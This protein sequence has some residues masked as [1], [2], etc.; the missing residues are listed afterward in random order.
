MT[1]YKNIVSSKRAEREKALKSAHQ[2]VAKSHAE[3]L[4]ATGK[5]HNNSIYE[6]FSFDILASQIVKNIA[7]EQWTASQV[8]EAYIARA[9]FAHQ[10][11]NCLTEGKIYFLS[12]L[13]PA[14]NQLYTTVLFDQARKEAKALD[15]DFVKT[16][17]LQGSLH[18]VPFSFKDQCTLLAYLSLLKR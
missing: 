7:N 14:S 9:A 16:K 1:N 4:N 6:L 11:T 3:F 12:D 15:D 13:K 18:G 8:V 17:K 5:C 2:Y 10:F